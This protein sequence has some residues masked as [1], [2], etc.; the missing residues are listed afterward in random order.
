MDSPTAWNIDDKFDY[1]SVNS[2]GFRVDYTGENID[3]A[4]LYSILY[5][6]NNLKRVM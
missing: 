6:C 1:L 5:I 2:N 4:F 3:F